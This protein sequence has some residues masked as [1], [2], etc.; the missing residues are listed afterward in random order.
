MNGRAHDAIRRRATDQVGCA[1]SSGGNRL[2]YTSGFDVTKK[3]PGPSLVAK[4]SRVTAA[5]NLPSPFSRRVLGLTENVA[6][7]LTEAKRVKRY[8]SRLALLE[9]VL[10]GEPPCSV[11]D[12]ASNRLAARTLHLARSA[13]PCGS[14]VPAGVPTLPQ[15]PYRFRWSELRSEDLMT[16]RVRPRRAVSRRPWDAPAPDSPPDT[17]LPTPE[18]RRSRILGRIDR[19][20]DVAPRL[21]KLRARHEVRGQVPRHDADPARLPTVDPLDDSL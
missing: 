15:A 5:P 3:A 4:P 16:T 19:S 10:D 13:R 20:V 11:P 17:R 8:S 21:Q 9:Q 18:G 1:T 2:Q 14:E 7:R 6:E 12:R